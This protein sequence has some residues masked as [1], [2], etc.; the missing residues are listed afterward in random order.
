M[1][2]CPILH[3]VSPVTH[4]SR[5]AFLPFLYDEEA[6]KLRERNSAFLAEGGSY[7]AGAT[8]PSKPG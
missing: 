6:A 5:Y 7:Q 3:A 1:F 4:G 2:S 8:R